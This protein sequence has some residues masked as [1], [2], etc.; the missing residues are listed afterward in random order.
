[1]QVEVGVGV[2]SVPA[3]P[4]GSGSEPSRSARCSQTP[5]T[6]TRITTRTATTV[7]TRRPRR[8][9][10]QRLIIR[11]HGAVGAPLTGTTTLVEEARIGAGAGAVATRLRAPDDLCR[12]GDTKDLDKIGHL[13]E[14]MSVAIVLSRL[15]QDDHGDEAGVDLFKP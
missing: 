14:Q 7:T 11:L 12:A 6:I 15:S 8:T 2:E 10:R 3:P 5:T 4:S 1:M 9:L 13:V